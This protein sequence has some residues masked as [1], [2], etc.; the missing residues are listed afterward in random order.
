[1]GIKRT[2]KLRTVITNIPMGICV[3]YVYLILG[4]FQPKETCSV[5][6]STCVLTAGCSHA[7][8]VEADS[9][10]AIKVAFLHCYF[11]AAVELKE[12]LTSS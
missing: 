10:V 7:I 8:H 6:P 3:L 11:S 9:G 12:K 5:R 2:V 4:L 1:M